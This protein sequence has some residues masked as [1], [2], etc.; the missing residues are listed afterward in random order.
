M[1]QPAM[2]ARR[3]ARACRARE[4]PEPSPQFLFRQP[5]DLAPATDCDEM[6]W[7]G[8]PDRVDGRV[9]SV[10]VHD[11]ATLDAHDLAKRPSDPQ[12]RV[13]HP[14]R[15]R[16]AGRAIH[17]A[18]SRAAPSRVSGAAQASNRREPVLRPGALA[19]G[20]RFPPPGSPK[21]LFSS[22]RTST[23]LLFCAHAGR[24][25]RLRLR[26]AGGPKPLAPLGPGPR[27]RPAT[28]SPSSRELPGRIPA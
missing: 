1:R 10:R 17:D 24:T 8:R 7:R 14:D 3:L 13:A 21:D 2:I 25:P 12:R 5:H 4:T 26:A 18:P 16:Q 28:G 15:A 23:H 9:G 6:R 22:Y 20:G 11:L 19:F 27:R